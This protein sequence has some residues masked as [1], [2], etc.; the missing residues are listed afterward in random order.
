[1]STPPD[2]YIDIPFFFWVSDLVCTCEK[3]VFNLDF[4]NFISERQ[5]NLLVSLKSLIHIE[6]I[7]GIKEK[8][9]LTLILSRSHKEKRLFKSFF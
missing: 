7:K 4:F 3:K 6:V 9:K 1:M 2:P 5:K 8:N